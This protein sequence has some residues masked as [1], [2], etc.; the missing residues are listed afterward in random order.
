V[1]ELR[2][3]PGA[4]G[5]AG[6]AARLLTRRDEARSVAQWVRG[7]W[8]GA[9]GEPTGRTAAVLCRNR[10][11]FGEVVHALRDEGLPVEIVGLGGLLSA[12]EVA[13]LVALLTV[14]QDPTRGDALMRLLTG[15]LCRLGP[16]DL[17][18]L[19]A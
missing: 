17:D 8:V 19:W 2:R 9:D 10:A 3:P 5:G 11:Q 14:A 16:A 4:E 18:G 13:D 15:P 12:P 6:P 1:A 7:H